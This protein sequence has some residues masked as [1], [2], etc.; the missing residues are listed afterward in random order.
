VSYLPLPDNTFRQVI[1]STM[2]FLEHR[3]VQ[4]EAL[5][6][7]GGMYWKRQ[8]GY[9]YLVKTT[10]DNRQRRLGPRTDETEHTYAAFT[11]RKK[12]TESRL[13]SL[14][15]ALKEAER[16][17]KALKAGRVHNIVVTLL[18]ALDFAGLGQ[19]FAVVG[20]HALF[21][22]EAAAGVSIASGKL[23][24]QGIDPLWDARHHVEFVTDLE[25][26][27]SSML[28]VLQRVDPTFRLQELGSETLINDR[29]FEVDFLLQVPADVDPHACPVAA[30]ET[31]LR[32]VPTVRAPEPTAVP[33]F[34]HLV[35]SVTGKMALM[36]TIAPNNFIE[37]KRWMAESAPNRT[38]LE[39]RRDLLQADIAQAL[40]D[41]QILAA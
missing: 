13:I 28:Q 4:A 17:N 40:L 25:H 9:E 30:N 33:G 11:T 5:R 37:V 16:L 35:I 31:G 32:S 24:A 18:Q 38:Q 7:A 41:E 26:I 39:R 20:T 12:D 1:D 14:R 3:R 19:H 22:Y 6:Y 10:V 2:V 27:D 29:G 23:V 15:D 8:G 34:E 21:A 36:R